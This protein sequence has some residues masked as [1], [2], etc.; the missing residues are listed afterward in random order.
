MSGARVSDATLN[1]L[2]LEGLSRSVCDGRS[3][4]VEVDAAVIY[5]IVEELRGRRSRERDDQEVRP[6]TAGAI[7]ETAT[8]GHERPRPSF[9]GDLL[10]GWDD[11][12]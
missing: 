4:V 8:P 6:N 1:D 11:D 3:R 9:A 2:A 12:E 7:G 10:Y 5:A